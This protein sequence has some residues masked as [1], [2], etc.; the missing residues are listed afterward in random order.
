MQTDE[1]SEYKMVTTM[2]K[3]FFGAAM[4]CAAMLTACGGG[5]KDGVR[6][7]SLSGEFDSLSYA[8]GAN[9]GYGID[10]DL[11]DIPFDYDRFEQGL[12]DGALDKVK[13][14][15]EQMM[16]QLRTYFMTKRLPRLQALRAQ[17]AEADS[18]R[19]A[20]GD[21]TKVEYGS[22]P[23]L[24]A[25]DGERDSISYAFGNNWGYSIRQSKAPIQIVW[26]T[27]AMKEV[28]EGKAR[29]DE[30]QMQ[31][32]IRYYFLEKLP[33]QNEK[34]SKEW[35]EKVSGKSGVKKT[36]SGLLYKIEK[37]GD[38]AVMAKDDRDRVKVHYKGTIR[39][40]EVFDASRFAE[41]SPEMQEMLKKRF[42]EE[43]DKDE[44]VEF[45]LNQVIKGWTEGMKLI[46]K[47]GKITLWIPSQLAYGQH[48][49]GNLIGPNEALRFDVDLVDVEP[50]FQA[51]TTKA[52]KAS[53]VVKF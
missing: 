29:M 14:D 33:A 45:P 43:Y 27:E 18:I 19:M 32:Y 7:G 5:N 25:T 24:F 21:S 46:G 44:P 12:E 16:M 20:N 50:F 3:T 1:Y 23:S 48:G 11:S 30:E 10:R 17:R 13:I 41:K 22:D 36:E 39:T 51:D 31:D 35:L 42:P 15:R 34:A 52:I 38:T 4:V 40:G 37:L 49:A 2:K 9:I 26:V 8:F 28:R 47:G 53:E 6:M